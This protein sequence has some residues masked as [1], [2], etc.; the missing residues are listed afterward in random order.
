[1]VDRCAG[2]VPEIRGGRPRQHNL[3]FDSRIGQFMPQRLT[4][5]KNKGF[6][7]AVYPVE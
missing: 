7:A 3:N 4:E 2:D 1:M 5:G 6:G